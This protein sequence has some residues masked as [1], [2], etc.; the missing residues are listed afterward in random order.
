MG[1]PWAMP[2]PNQKIFN[3]NQLTYTYHNCLSN[4][5]G[6]IADRGCFGYDKAFILKHD[7]NAVILAKGDAQLIL[8]PKYQGKVFTSTAEGETGHSFGWIN[9]KAFDGSLDPHMN[10]YGGENR[11]WLGPEGGKF[12]LFFMPRAKM[13]FANWKTP[14]AF[15]TEPWLVEWKS[16]TATM[17]T[18]DMQLRNYAGTILNIHIR[19]AVSLLSPQEISRL[20]GL[21]TPVTVK[22]VGY[23]TVNTL[24]NTGKEAWDERSGMPCLWLLD[25]FPPSAETIIV[26]PYLSSIPE[27]KPATTDYFG[28]IPADRIKTD[29]RTLFFKADG[30]S[31]GKLGIHPLRA[32]NRAGSYDGK[33]HIL[34]IILFDMDNRAKY[35]NQEW[36]TIKPPFSGDA[37]NAYNDGPLANGK[38]MGPFYELESV[39]PAAFLTPG[40]SLTHRHCVFHFTGSEADLSVIS[41]KVLSVDLKTVKKAL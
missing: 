3:L 26:M 8:S 12:S 19:R 38:Q 17:L 15:D 14:A 32:G 33:N 21:N 24:A 9:Y 13:E 40:D 6:Q 28:E 29:G 36:K 1:Y 35:L 11:L 22:Q 37:I 4:D 10:A 39:S 34:T 5:A 25:M 18:K 27:S 30:K 16:D 7:T 41:E 2:L 31:R 23:Q 20:F